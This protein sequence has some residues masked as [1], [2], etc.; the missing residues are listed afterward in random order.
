MLTYTV[1]R[2]QGEPDWSAAPVALL[3]CNN[4]NWPYAP[5]SKAQVVLLDNGEMAVRL[6]SYEEGPVSHCTVNDGFVYKD[7]C[8]EF[9]VDP[10]PE[11]SDIY[12]NFES[13]HIGALFINYGEETDWHFRHKTTEL[14]LVHPEV[15]CFSGQDADGGYWGVTYKIPP[16]FW[17]T[18]YGTS[19]LPSGHKMIGSFFKCGDETARPHFC[20]W[21]KIEFERPNFHLPQFFGTLVIE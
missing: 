2:Q 11:K 1:K 20:S 6:W 19:D 8:I 13:N 7:S 17:K 16:V 4:W 5:L 9:F 10:Y 3:D 12:L 14:G 21:N 15:S 18:I